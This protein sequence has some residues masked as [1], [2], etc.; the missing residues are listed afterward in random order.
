MIPNTLVPSGDLWRWASLLVGSSERPGLSNGCLF[1]VEYESMS[2]NLANFKET[3]VN[4]SLR[5][6]SQTGPFSGVLNSIAI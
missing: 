4:Q 3:L 2:Y 6:D 5:V 1:Y